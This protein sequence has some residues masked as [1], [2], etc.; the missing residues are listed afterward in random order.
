MKF[1][2]FTSFALLL[3]ACAST[4]PVATPVVGTA[5]RDAHGGYQV[6]SNGTTYEMLPTLNA[7]INNGTGVTL[8]RFDTATMKAFGA[9]D[10]NVTVAAGLGNSTYFAGI[11]GTPSATVP[12][13]G[14]ATY[15]GLFG[16][17]R[18]GTNYYAGINL[19][20]DFGANTL[21]GGAATGLLVDGTIS[22]SSVTGTATFQGTDTG[23]LTGGFYGPAASRTVA[24]TILGPNIAGIVVTN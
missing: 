4:P 11:S 5:T 16:L 18:G 10:T 3:G 24:L 19:I 23:D 6:V 7:P 12:T 9:S 20:A 22:G 21:K 2:A 8:E 14:G 13:S 17:T 1:F 15:T